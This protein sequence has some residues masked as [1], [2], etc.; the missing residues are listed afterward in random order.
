MTAKP[1][2]EV[3]GSQKR[4]IPDKSGKGKHKVEDDKTSETT[5]PVTDKDFPPTGK[6][7]EN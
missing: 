1:R 2:D 4:I 7:M 3:G 6:G 5:K